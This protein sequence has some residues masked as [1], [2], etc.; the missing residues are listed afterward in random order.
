MTHMLSCIVSSLIDLLMMMLIPCGE[1]YV[2]PAL[3]Y[4]AGHPV[5]PIRRIDWLQP[6]VMCLSDRTLISKI[7]GTIE[8]LSILRGLVLQTIS[9]EAVHSS[10]SNKFRSVQIT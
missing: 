3:K 2:S 5:I 10:H 9:L 8:M 4:L 6:I 1:H 7:V